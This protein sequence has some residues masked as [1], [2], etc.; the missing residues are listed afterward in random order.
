[1]NNILPL[2][3]NSL[4]IFAGAVLLE[5]IVFLI[6]VAKRKLN[7]LRG[8]F[9]VLVGNAITTLFCFFLPAGNGELGFG[10]YAWYTIAFALAV[11]FEWVIDVV[12]FR[13]R[14]NKVSNLRFF[15]CSLIGNLVTFALL[16]ILASRGLLN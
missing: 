2:S 7:I 15:F 10:F 16:T 13:N 6:L 4:Y 3:F 11:V 14:P 9:A 5:F 12:F 1:M 8:F